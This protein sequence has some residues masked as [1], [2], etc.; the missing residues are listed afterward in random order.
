MNA[1]V[2]RT[3]DGEWIRMQFDQNAKNVAANSNVGR[4]TQFDWKAKTGDG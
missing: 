3:H 1:T 2:L 4:R